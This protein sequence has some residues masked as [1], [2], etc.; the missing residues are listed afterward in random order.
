[1]ANLLHEYEV[2]INNDLTLN[3][4]YFLLRSSLD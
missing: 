2:A 3:F 4:T 1:M